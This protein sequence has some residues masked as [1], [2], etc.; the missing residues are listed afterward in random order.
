MS[1]ATVTKICFLLHIFAFIAAYAER[2]RRLHDI[3]S[4]NRITKYIF[5]YNF[6]FIFSDNVSNVV[7]FFFFFVF[8][9]SHEDLYKF[10]VS[11]AREGDNPVH[12]SLR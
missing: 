4:P 8:P 9:Q 10:C 1:T 2:G 3:H 12:F 5:R 6:A 7:F 11:E